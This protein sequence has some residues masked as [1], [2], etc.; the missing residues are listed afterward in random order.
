MADPEVFLDALAVTARRSAPV[1]VDAVLDRFPDAKTVLDLGGLHGEYS[2]EFVRRGLRATLQDLPTMV[3]FVRRRGEL[4]AAGVDLFAGSFFETLPPG[5]FDIAF[6][7]GIT[8][9]FDGEHN[10]LLYRRL[11]PVVSPS[12][13]VAVISFLRHRQPLADVFAVQMLA[14]ANGGDTHGEEE[15]RSW[16]G[17]AGF[18]VDPG[19]VDLP[20]RPQSAI[21][22]T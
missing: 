13:G 11:R 9:T 1:V 17:E 21:F 18:V 14:N 19:T 5:P 3:D 6:C 10:R 20:G 4:A 15:Y 8:H 2:L 22:A 12:G 7:T 16:L